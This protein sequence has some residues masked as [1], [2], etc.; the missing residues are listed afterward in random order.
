MAAADKLNGAYWRKRAIELAEKQQQEVPHDRGRQHHGQGEHHVQQALDQPGQ[1]G[2][3]VCGKNARKEHC[4]AGNGRNAQRV[5]KRIPV[6]Y[7]TM[8]K[9]TLSKIAAAASVV[10]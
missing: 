4:H 6:H 9:P 2:Y 1:F 7:F 5:I 3:I 10:R 8:A